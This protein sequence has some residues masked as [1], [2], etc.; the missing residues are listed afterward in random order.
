MTADRPPASHFAAPDKRKRS[1][2]RALRHPLRIVAFAFG[3]YALTFSYASG[4]GITSAC[5]GASLAVVLGEWLA[6][7]NLRTWPVVGI[8]AVL[9]VAFCWSA[10]LTSSATLFSE[11][12]GHRAAL[13][14]RESLQFFAA[15]F[16]ALSIVRFVA[17]RNPNLLFL[18]VVYSAFA[19]AVAL[20]AHRD[21]MIARPLW[22]SDYAWQRNLDPTHLLIGAGVVA[23]GILL[24]LI[25]L[26]RRKRFPWPVVIGLPLLALLT[27]SVIRSVGPPQ[28]EPEDGIGIK[29]EELGEDP[30]DMKDDYPSS[31]DPKEGDAGVKPQ[32]GSDGGAGNPRDGG[33]DGGGG[34][35]SKDGGT[36][37]GSGNTQE[38][39]PN[40][41]NPNDPN[42][43]ATP[44]PMAIVVFETDYEPPSESFYFRQGSWS[45]WN[46]SRLL[47]TKMEE[48]DTDSL[49]AYPDVATQIDVPKSEHREIVK[50]RVAWIAE[51]EFPF[52]LET[53][54]SFTPIANP[55]TERFTRAYR[56]VSSAQKTDYQELLQLDSG[57]PEW[58]E[59]LRELYLQ[60]HPDERYARLAEEIVKK[61]PEAYQDSPLA[62]AVAIKL[63][64]DK[65]LVYS[66]S[67]RHAGVKDPTTHFLFGNRVGYC[68]HFAHAAVFL[69]R[70]LGIPS[71][72]SNGYMVPA[73]NRRGGSSLLIRSGDAHAWPELYLDG[74]GWI[75][76]DIS[77]E[78]VLDQ[79][80]K[81]LDENL[82]R[83][84]GEMARE[85]PAVPED[86]ED[87]EEDRRDWAGIIGKSLGATALFALVFFYGWK[88][89]RRIAPALLKRARVRVGYR[90]LLDRMFEAGLTREY[91]ETREAFSRRLEAQIPSL[92]FITER[93]V[94]EKLGWPA[95]RAHHKPFSSEQGGLSTEQLLKNARR[96]LR[97]STR[98][99]RRILGLLYPFTP[100][101]IR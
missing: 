76:L 58:P 97:A 101:H 98:W 99:W 100:I 14:I 44:A 50:G 20:E 33:A 40:L 23:A 27:V 36:D 11:N 59:K 17:A 91:G 51:H 7:S 75:V 26:E 61:L 39:P 31:G 13:E 9:T 92:R 66:T 81:A 29:T 70:S 90:A 15:F 35:Q 34:S 42:P 38:T 28:A 21:G 53:P 60:P 77:A 63:Y 82:Q 49:R 18:E 19:L 10:G 74:I 85:K 47:P 72:I 32:D 22:L 57:N 71:R 45:E 3:A 86:L 96:E 8:L 94:A 84:L 48:A 30:E 43:N 4:V 54:L 87:V 68:V 83:M 56:F 37:G 95:G 24:L 64:L 79:P 16:G 67:E 12:F 88:G 5:I 80:G 62:K 78:R 2:L 46:G 1:W 52:A 69:W 6:R 89:W 93:H 65:E 41:D 55:N 73:E 25:A